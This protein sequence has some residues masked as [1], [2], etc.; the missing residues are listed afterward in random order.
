MSDYSI[1]VPEMQRHKICLETCQGGEFYYTVYVVT[2]E[3][4][5]ND[6]DGSFIG[7]I[8]GENNHFLGDALEFVP[9]GLLYTHK[10][11]EAKVIEIIGK[12][13]LELHKRRMAAIEDLQNSQLFLTLKDLI[14]ETLT[15]E[16]KACD[17]DMREQ[18]P[19]GRNGEVRVFE[20]SLCLLVKTSDETW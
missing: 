18:E 11:S 5:C 17:H 15:P 13:K 6:R 1:P 9:D 10:I 16:Q 8:L 19:S 2:D 14:S 7:Y 3:L 12:Q 20:C 4:F